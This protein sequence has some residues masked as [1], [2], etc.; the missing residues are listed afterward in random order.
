M[1][2]GDTLFRTAAVLREVLLGRQVTAA[3]GRPGGA[4]LARV[5]GSRVDRVG[6]VGKHLLVGFDGGLSLHTHLGMNGSWH[7]YRAGERWRR[8]P[9][10]AVCVLE[11]AT[12]VAVC[13]DAPVAELIETRALGLHP[14]L[15]RLGPD[16][17][18]PEPDIG[19]ALARLDDVPSTTTIAEGL[20]DQRAMAGLGNVYR[21]EVLFIERVDPFLA[22]GA[23]EPDARERLVRTGARLLRANRDG[24]RRTTTGRDAD[25]ERL[26]VYRRT[27]RPC[28]R[29]GTAVR[30]TVIGELP[31]RVYWCP[32][33]QP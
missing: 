18:E 24:P 28:R 17:I 12:A 29:C 32:T 6:S 23:V 16:L 13:F 1:P 22:V 5:V 27:G 15:A 20:L 21:S 9:A 33:C 11:T 31:R 3:R 10:R 4:Q 8:S 19:A 30:S 2:E 7:R 26:W 14:T 25:G